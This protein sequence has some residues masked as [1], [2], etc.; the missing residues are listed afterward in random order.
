MSVFE[1]ICDF[2]LII[3]LHSSEQPGNHSFVQMER[4]AHRPHVLC[5]PTSGFKAGSMHDFPIVRYLSHAVCATPPRPHLIHRTHLPLLSRIQ[6]LKRASMHGSATSY[7]KRVRA[8]QQ[9]WRHL[10]D[11]SLACHAFHAS[12][13]PVPMPRTAFSPSLTRRSVSGSVAAFALHPSRL[14]L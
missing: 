4:S 13:V 3:H 14:T 8:A 6:Y 12:H 2:V 7:P 9:A 10:R 5:L 1:P 11:L